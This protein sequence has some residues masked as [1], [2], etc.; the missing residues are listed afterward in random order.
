MHKADVGSNRNQG[1]TVMRSEIVKLI[2]YL[3]GPF[4]DMR[5]VDLISLKD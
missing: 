1:N 4:Y 3:K 2:L 5:R